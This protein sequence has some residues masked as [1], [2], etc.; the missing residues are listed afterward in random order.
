MHVFNLWVSCLQG[1]LSL[2]HSWD[3][4]P[5]S[6]G[7]WPGLPQGQA[8]RSPWPGP[9]WSQSP[10]FPLQDGSVPAHR[11]QE[12]RM[13]CGT[14]FHGPLV[15]QWLLCDVQTESRVTP[16]VWC[17]S[18]NPGI[19][20]LSSSVLPKPASPPCTPLSS[21]GHRAGVT[22]HFPRFSCS[23]F[24]PQGGQCDLR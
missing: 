8:L 15:A 9:Q 18:G 17:G 4:R 16:G 13:C 24:C 20:G 14:A 2:C 5:V 7:L 1:G 22:S 10:E 12:V 21:A 6:P 23:P 19:P 11:G 3:S